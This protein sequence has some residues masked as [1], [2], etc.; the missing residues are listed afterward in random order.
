[1]RRTESLTDFVCR[2]TGQQILVQDRV[3]KETRK[4]SESRITHDIKVIVPF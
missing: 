1:M 2:I 3:C 4:Q